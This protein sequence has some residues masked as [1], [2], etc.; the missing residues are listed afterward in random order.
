MLGRLIL[1]NHRKRR[2]D[3]IVHLADTLLVAIVMT[4]QKAAFG[5]FLRIG[6]GYLARGLAPLKRL[7]LM[8]ILAAV[9]LRA[10]PQALRGPMLHARGRPII[11]F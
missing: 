7:A 5:A 11:V 10:I 2:D 1:R 8:T 3:H 6:L 9:L 4:D